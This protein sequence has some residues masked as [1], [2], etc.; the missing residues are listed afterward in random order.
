YSRE[1]LLAQNLNTPVSINQDFKSNIAQYDIQMQKTSKGKTRGKNKC[2]ILTL[3]NWNVEGLKGV[4]TNSP[5]TK[6]FKNADII[7]LSETFCTEE[8]PQFPGY[9]SIH[10]PATQ[11]TLGRPVGGIAL[12]TKPYIN[13][14]R[15]SIN[16]NKIIA[17]ST[18]G[19]ICYYYFNPRCE[20]ED[21]VHEI[22]G[23]IVDTE[24]TC[25][26]MGDFNCRIDTEN[27][28]GQT[29]V[30]FMNSQNFSLVTDPNI[31]TYTAHNGSSCIDLIF[32]RT[33]RLRYLK[34]YSVTLDP[35]RKH[36]RVS[37]TLKLRNTIYKKTENINRPRRKF[38]ITDIQQNEKIKELTAEHI[39]DIIT[40]TD[41][42]L[43][44][45]SKNKPKLHHHKPWFDYDC[46]IAKSRAINSMSQHTEETSKTRKDYVTLIKQK[47]HD[48]EEEKL[49]NKCKEAEIK[50]WEMFQ[51]PKQNI[52]PIDLKSLDIHFNNLLSQDITDTDI[53]NPFRPE[54]NNIELTDDEWSTEITPS[55]ISNAVKLLK[56]KKAA[57][58]NNIYN[59]HIKISFE[60]FQ[61]WW[62]L[63][64]NLLFE[65]SFVPEAWRNAYLKVLYKGKGLTNDPNSYRGIALLDTSYKLYTRILNDR[66]MKT[67]DDKLPDEQFGFRRN[68]SCQKA[69]AILRHDIKETLNKPK[70]AMYA[71]F[72]DFQ[73][74]FDSLDRQILIKS[75]QKI[76]IQGK[77]LRAIVNII[78]YNYLTLDN[79]VETSKNLIKQEKGIIQGDPLSSTMFIIYVASLPEIFHKYPSINS[80][81]FADDLVV[82]SENLEDLKNSMKDLKN[83]CTTF[84]MTV[85][86]SKTKIMKFRNGG[87][88]KSTDKIEYDNKNI[89]FTNEYMYL[90]ILMQ[91]TMTI[92]KHI[93][94]KSIKAS[95]SMGSINN[96]KHL[97]LTTIHKI[98]LIKIW[99]I[100]C[101]SF[102]TLAEDLQFSHLL[103]LDKIKAKLYKNAMCLHKN[104]S[105]TLVFQMANIKRFGEETIEKYKNKIKLSE[106][107]KYEEIIEN[108]NMQFVIN[109][110]TDGPA[111]KTNTWK[112]NNQGNRHVITRYTSHG[113][114]HL[115][116]M[117]KEYHTDYEGCTC[118]LC[119]LAIEGRYHLDHHINQDTSLTNLIQQL[120]S[121][122]VQSQSY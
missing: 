93:V 12:Y 21:I 40:L 7:C 15:V 29:L 28:K 103:E 71:I 34:N 32:L 55:E 83:W 14:N 84:K 74:A 78:S 76:G 95:H 30:E 81:M 5:E 59:E 113:F 16:E 92:T 116:C 23:D 45:A 90:G 109:K 2:S 100:V 53:T 54:I 119:K 65:N 52:S 48:Y 38:S 106:I 43:E 99:P 89:E 27:I 102:E 46:K 37:A 110:F 72:I 80:L 112:N 26:V 22:T 44:A 75:L 98:F 108:K 107:E 10:Q 20:I 31:K 58:P 8:P 24:G 33:S 36:Q 91:P 97:K 87:K 4:S 111:F 82:Y 11:G 79:G 1:D 115:I 77:T 19:Q 73:K 63:Y 64:L 42:L 88:L 13:M 70:G 6:L 86:I 96:M 68:R 62:Y 17:S 39:D 3:I 50:P 121:R 49:L 66:I 47:R 61:E 117:K 60:Y 69:I 56:N 85:N 25:L 101:Y 57:G 104:T 94:S 105:N 51:K 35:I 9:Y 67:I 120:L 18:F 114:H 41:I 122:S 118:K